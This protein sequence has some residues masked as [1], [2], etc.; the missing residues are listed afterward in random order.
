MLKFQSL[1]KIRPSV[2]PS[3]TLY[4][5]IKKKKSFPAGARVAILAQAI[6]AQGEDI[7]LH[8]FFICERYSAFRLGI[9]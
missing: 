3:V 4:F 5:I 7:S 1:L 9:V 8:T 6:L 2:R